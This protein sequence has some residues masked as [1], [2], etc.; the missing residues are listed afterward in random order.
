MID[1]LTDI[2]TQMVLFWGSIVICLIGTLFFIAGISFKKADLVKYGVISSF[3][4][5]LPMLAA[6][7]LRWMQTGHIPSI[8]PY[9]VYTVYAGGV[10]LFYVFIQ[11]RKPALKISGLVV[12]P[13]VMLM[14]GVGVMSPNEITVQPQTYFTYWL[15]VHIIF[16]TLA[17]GAVAVSAGLAVIYLA[18]HRQE[19][20]GLV[21]PLLAA[22]PQLERLDYWCYRLSIFAFVTMG[23]M[24]ASGAFWAF[25]SWGRFW[26]WDP[27]ET[28]SLVSWLVYGGYLHLRIT[29]VKGTAAAWLCLVAVIVLV[30]SFFGAPY[31]YPTLHDRFVNP[32][33][34]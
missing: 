15:W 3:L 25:D 13:A 10:L 16:A 20:K 7:V 4:A 9:E 2:Q 17:L 34:Y 21:N 30:F 27:I 28:W 8:G 26:G 14:T 12:L 29:G 5:L 1:I 23:L 6:L 32:N 18:K 19:K 22:L 33:A 11:W 24:I 31:L